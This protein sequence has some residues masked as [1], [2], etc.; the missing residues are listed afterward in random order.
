MNRECEM[1]NCVL[2]F[3]LRF[4]PAV[5][6]AKPPQVPSTQKTYASSAPEGAYMR[7]VV[8]LQR[9]MEDEETQ[10]VNQSGKSESQSNLGLST[11]VSVS[12]NQSV[13]VGQSVSQS[14]SCKRWQ[15]QAGRQAATL[16]VCSVRVCVSRNGWS[17]GWSVGRWLASPASGPGS[18]ARAPRP[19]S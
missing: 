1:K 16:L 6:S 15:R 3:A 9:N 2:R 18:R 14:A 11:S 8:S 7:L 17:I 10:S 12:I 19:C 5:L 13:S 4:F